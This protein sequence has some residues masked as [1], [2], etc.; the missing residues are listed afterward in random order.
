MLSCHFG[1]DFRGNLLTFPLVLLKTTK[2]A[3]ERYEFS[4]FMESKMRH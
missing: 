2:M 3:G 4:K 1:R